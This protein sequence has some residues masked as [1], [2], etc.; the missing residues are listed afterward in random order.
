VSTCVCVCVCVCVLGYAVLTW[1]VLLCCVELC[2]FA[3]FAAFQSVIVFIVSGSCVRCVDVW[4]MCLWQCAVCDGL[5]VVLDHVCCLPVHFFLSH[6]SCPPLL[7][8]ILLSPSALC[9]CRSSLAALLEC[10]E[11]CGGVWRCELGCNLLQNRLCSVGYRRS[12]CVCL[13]VLVGSC[14]FL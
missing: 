7:S 14:P 10:V 12:V 1:R 2:N 9:L 4:L 11:V 8:H 6:H 3:L 5:L 13:R